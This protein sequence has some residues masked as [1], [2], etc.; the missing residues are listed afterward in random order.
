MLPITRRELFPKS[1]PPVQAVQAVQATTL[2]FWRSPRLHV[3]LAVSLPMP[4]CAIRRKHHPLQPRIQEAFPPELPASLQRIMST[5]TQACLSPRRVHT[6][7]SAS[8]WHHRRLS[9]HTHTR[10]HTDT[11]K[12]AGRSGTLQTW[13]RFA[14]PNCVILIPSRPAAAAL[15]PNSAYPSLLYLPPVYIVDTYIPANSSK[16]AK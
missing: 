15:P 16:N 14:A 6:A 11:S 7:A 13:P 8:Q 4:A 5:H 1:G 12:H 3:V 9:A 2:A 10:S